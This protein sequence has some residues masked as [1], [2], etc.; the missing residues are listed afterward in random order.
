MS[1]YRFLIKS[2]SA[3]SVN[4]LHARIIPNMSDPLEQ[5]HLFLFS[6]TKHRIIQTEAIHRRQS[7]EPASTHNLCT[8][9]NTKRIERLH[10]AKRDVA[11]RF[12]ICARFLVLQYTHFCVP[13][14]VS[15]DVLKYAANNIHGE[16]QF[17]MFVDSLMKYTPF[18]HSVDGWSEIHEIAQCGGIRVALI[19]NEKFLVWKQSLLMIVSGMHVNLH[20]NAHLCID[21][22]KRLFSAV[23]RC[24]HRFPLECFY[25]ICGDEEMFR[26]M[27]H[28]VLHCKLPIFVID[29]DF[30]AHFVS[31]GCV[32]DVCTIGSFHCQ[33]LHFSI[34]RQ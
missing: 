31:F 1:L 12:Y 33:Y 27:Q 28:S 22:K 5:S 18:I 20:F 8:L 17:V 23:F 3:S 19:Q 10:R 13:L 14:F 30:D 9:Q 6:Q 32:F 24:F 16:L 29:S 26:F 11:L 7:N 34:C 25:A 21:L 15:K 4:Q 2:I